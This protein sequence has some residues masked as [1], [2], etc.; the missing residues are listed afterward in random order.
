MPTIRR[1]H[2]KTENKKKKTNHSPREQST[3]HQH[4]FKNTYNRTALGFLQESN[5]ADSL[6]EPR[7]I[8]SLFVLFII[9]TITSYWYHQ[10]TEEKKEIGVV[11][12]PRSLDTKQGLLFVVIFILGYCMVQVRDGLLIRP[13]PV[14]W[15]FVHGM[16]M[17]YVIILLF[18]LP[19]HPADVRTSLKTIISPSLGN[20]STSSDYSTNCRFT[21]NDFSKQ[22]FEFFTL[23]H[24]IGYIIKALVYRDWVLLVAHSFLFEI[25]EITFSHLLPNFQECWWDHV[26]L[27]IFGAN[28]LGSILG[29][30]LVKYLE[31]RIGKK[32]IHMNW[33]DKKKKLSNIADNQLK[34]RRIL[35]QFTPLSW[36]SD[37]F[38]LTTNSTHFIAAFI[39]VLC[40]LEIETSIFFLKYFL[41]I[42]MSNR[43]IFV[44]MS[45]KAALTAHAYREWYVY[46]VQDEDDQD[47]DDNIMKRKMKNRR[48][49]R[50]GHN[51]WLCIAVIVAELA[52]CLKWSI[53]PGFDR[54]YPPRKVTFA[55]LFFFIIGSIWYT[56]RYQMKFSSIDNDNN[57]SNNNSNQKNQTNYR[58]LIEN[59]VGWLTIFPLFLLLLDEIGRTMFYEG[60]TPYAPVGRTSW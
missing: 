7:T 42:E 57:T 5:F 36:D 22:F 51:A 55:W 17:I 24:L 47:D 3:R 46:M 48:W 12:H 33:S 10:S 34:A 45:T 27:D 4:K 32:G 38:S 9:I 53:N 44:L 23:S 58:K 15:R 37:T 14:I 11:M 43:Y 16:G 6:Y 18:L 39:V 31:I 59:T 25:V 13:H 41:W 19:F 21:W 54:P 20:F 26:V 49:N 56:L 29:M 50:L 60:D 8:Q 40:G 35:L 30:W 1:Q 52:I 2:V 28:L